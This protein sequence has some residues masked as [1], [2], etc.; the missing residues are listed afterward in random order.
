VSFCVYCGIILSFSS[1]YY[2]QGNGVE[3]SSEK[4]VL[5][6]SKRIVGDKKRSQDSKLRYSL[7]ANRI[8]RKKWKSHFELVYGMNVSLP[9]SLKIPIYKLMK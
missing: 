4:N 1:N 2:P 9:I 8:P 6:I 3:K 5:K 7:W